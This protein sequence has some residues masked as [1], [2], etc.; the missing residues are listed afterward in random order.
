MNP[1]ESP[2]PEFNM[3]TPAV[4]EGRQA[5]FA[6]M[7][8]TPWGCFNCQKQVAAEFNKEGEFTFHCECSFVVPLRHGTLEPKEFGRP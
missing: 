2:G 5:W 8:P 6:G 4:L 1:D 7:Q 3:N